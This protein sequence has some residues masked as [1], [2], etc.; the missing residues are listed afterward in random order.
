MSELPEASRRVAS[1]AE[2]L[3]LAI[4]IKVMAASTRTAEEAAAAC[5][6]DVGQ[7]VKSLIFKGAESGRGY[8]LLVSGRNRVAEL[9]VASALGENIIR[10]DAK[11]VRDLTG[12]AIGGIPPFGHAS[13][14]T[15]FMDRDLLHYTRVY[16][17]AGTPTTTFAVEPQA[18]TAATGATVID[19]T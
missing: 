6:C 4:E 15:T 10:P 11:F 14:I 1:A 16:A 7:I 2:A 8:L 5:G 12:F 3:R 18:L 9:K 19:V 13:P 17:A